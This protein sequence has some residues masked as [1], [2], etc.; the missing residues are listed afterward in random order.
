M[1]NDLLPKQNYLKS[2][3]AMEYLTT[4]GWA[5]IVIAVVLGT[6]FSLGLFTPGTFVNTTCVFP[7]EFECLS[8]ILGS[9]NS[10]LSVNVQQT[11]SSS[12]NI[13][14][15]GCNGQSKVANM[16]TLGS[17]LTMTI[18]S[19]QTFAITCYNNGTA[20]SV[21]SGQIF[22]GYVIINY[23]SLQTNFPHTVIGSIIAKVV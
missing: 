23:T 3:S 22:K 6:L 19:N 15:Y 2:Q 1:D 13:T 12:I 16:I 21:A 18:G 17:P 20:V 4:Y 9:T 8:A 10:T 5:I 7:A 11:A 14:A